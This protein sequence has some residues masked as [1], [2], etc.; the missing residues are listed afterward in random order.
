M[1]YHNFVVCG[2]FSMEKMVFF[3]ILWGVLYCMTL[4]F[5]EK[6]QDPSLPI[7]SKNTNEAAIFFK[8]QEIEEPAVPIE[9][10]V[11]PLQIRLFSSLDAK[12]L[13]YYYKNTWNSNKTLEQNKR[14]LVDLFM[15]TCIEPIED[16]L[17]VDKG[18][19]L[20]LGG[21]AGAIL[22]QSAQV[23]EVR[24]PELVRIFYLLADSPTFCRL[25][26]ALV[27]KY[28]TMF[29]RPQKAVFLF[30]KGEASHASY[31]TVHYVINLRTMDNTILSALDCTK[32]KLLFGGTI[33]HEML[34]WYHKVSDSSAY[35]RRA[36]T[37]NC[38]IRR[39]QEY[40]YYDFPGN[41]H[42]IAKYFS[43]DEEYYTMYGLKEEDGDLV[44]DTL[45]EATYT[46]EQYGYI[47]GSH[48]AF[49][50]HYPDEKKFILNTRDSALLKFFQKNP[51]PEFGKEEF[52]CMQ[53]KT[54]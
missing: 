49:P 24:P 53:V 19:V 20:K 25:L 5:D 2:K 46:L 50:R 27:T 38:I 32:H 31:S 36:N 30:T 33:F 54:K 14:D 22:L 6:L 39:L 41:R 34:H 17:P 21:Q 52:V 9:E 7:F 12:E 13:E 18:V 40:N 43:N 37:M 15:K 26:R 48:V 1:C 35:E 8:S 44:L 28:K 10:Y 45:C 3:A 4:Y 51:P 23:D 16:F 47:R 11:H 29:Y 42:Q